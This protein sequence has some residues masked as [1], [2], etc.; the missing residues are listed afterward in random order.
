MNSIL[1]NNLCFNFISF[2]PFLARR[3]WN[4]SLHSS[5]FINDLMERRYLSLISQLIYDGIAKM[6]HL[7]VRFRSGIRYARVQTYFAGSVCTQCT[8][9][10]YSRLILLILLSK[11]HN[12][13]F[14]F[15]SF[16]PF[17]ARRKWNRSLHSSSFINDLMERGWHSQNVSSDSPV[18]FRN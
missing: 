13:C 2:L 1:N 9:A 11:Q 8:P 15:I 6:F 12:L 7:T 17:L 5:S 16:L 10:Q 4:R 14:N 18:P 3:K